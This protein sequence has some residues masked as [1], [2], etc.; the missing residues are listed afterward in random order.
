MRMIVHDL[1]QSVWNNI[2]VTINKGDEVISD[3]GTIENCMDFRG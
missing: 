1:E 2:G 3:N